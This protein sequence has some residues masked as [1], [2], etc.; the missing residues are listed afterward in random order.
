MIG[1]R[2]WIRALQ[3]NDGDATSGNMKMGT[4]LI[5]SEKQHNNDQYFLILESS[6]HKYV[7]KCIHTVIT[8][9]RNM[10]A[11]EDTIH[12]ELQHEKRTKLMKTVCLEAMNR[13]L[14]YF[15]QCARYL[16]IVEFHVNEL[17]P[18]NDN[19][20]TKC[21]RSVNLN[22]MY[23]DMLSVYESCES[24]LRRNVLIVLNIARNLILSFWQ[25][26]MSDYISI[27]EHSS[28]MFQRDVSTAIKYVSS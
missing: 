5:S 11:K 8:M 12:C 16:E 25:R 24:L 23:T 1:A 13:L 27:Y 9:K 20:N 7:L 4:A 19:I 21:G 26:I 14:R 18:T 3:M 28:S 15:M 6:F 10:V 17:P 2:K 22:K